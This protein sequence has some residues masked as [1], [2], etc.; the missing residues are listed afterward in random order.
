MQSPVFLLILFSNPTRV[1]SSKLSLFL[2]FLLLIFIISFSFTLSL[3]T[4]GQNNL[5][6][7]L[8]L[9]HFSSIKI[10]RVIESFVSSCCIITLLSLL[11]SISIEYYCFPNFF[12]L[13]HFL[14]RFFLSSVSKYFLRS[15]SLFT[16]TTFS[17][18]FFLLSYKLHHFFHF[19]YFHLCFYRF[20][21][22]LFLFPLFHFSI[23][24]LS[25]VF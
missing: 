9:S 15:F 7:S 1:L 25:S 21:S 4:I 12:F 16:L 19:L 17:A 13:D 8:F 10:T 5:P 2:L 18:F 11:F 6:C 14:S 22:S 23:L 24:S 3:L 20:Y